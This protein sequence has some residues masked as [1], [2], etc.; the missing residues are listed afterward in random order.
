MVKG[1][2]T[3]LGEIGEAG[4]YALCLLE[5]A[6]RVN[7]RE[8]NVVD[9]LEQLI[10]RSYIYYNYSNPNDNDNFY[11]KNPAMVMNYL[12]GGTW[13]VERQ[14][15]EYVPKNNEW[16]VDRWERNA[17]GVTYGHFNLPAQKGFDQ[18]DSLADSKTVK[19]GKI[20]SKRV[21]SKV[22]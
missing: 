15:A 9:I 22:S 7:G 8:Y 10:K 14:P 5:I 1:I 3:F 11:V 13:K 18:W 12:C 2:Q 19:F 16:V 21:I 6:E 20:A 17:T 4:C